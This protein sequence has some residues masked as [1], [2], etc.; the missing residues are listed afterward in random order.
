V[1]VEWKTPLS[2][3]DVFD[4]LEEDNIRYVVVSGVAVALHGHARPVID[5]DLVRDAA[6]AAAAQRAMATLATAGFV[7]SVPLPLSM[8]TVLRMF[9][10]SQREVDVF[11]RYHIPFEELWTGSKHMRAG[12]HSVRVISFAHL[13]RVKRHIGRPHDLEDVKAL[14]ALQPNA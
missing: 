13:I 11:V 2:Y 8:L 9:D 3:G 12:D 10:R 14:L 6:P 1:D 7:P 4:R 5:L